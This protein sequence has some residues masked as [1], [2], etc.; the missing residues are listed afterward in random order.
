VQKENI[1]LLTLQS[2]KN[3]VL[4]LIIAIYV[5]GSD[6]CEQFRIKNAC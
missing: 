2:R 5:H 4:L 1:N 3:V 6:I